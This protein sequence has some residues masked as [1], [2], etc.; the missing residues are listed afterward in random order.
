MASITGSIPLTN[1]IAPNSSA[2]SYPI[3]KPIYGLGGL[4]TV[5]NTGERDAITSARR[6][7]GMVVYVADIQKY[8][9]LKGPTGNGDWTE[10]LLGSS[11]GVTGATGARG[12]TGSTGAGYLATS[13]SEIELSGFSV[14]ESIQ[15]SVFAIPL[16]AYSIGQ[17]LIILSDSNNFFIGTVTNW[18]SVASTV[19]LTITKLVG[20]ATS[21]S[22]TINLVGEQG[23]QGNTGNTGNP[24]DLYKTTS[25][26]LI[27]LDG[28]TT[29]EALTVIIPSGFAYSK[30]QGVLLANTSSNKL[31]ATVSNYS[32]ITLSIIVD[33]IFGTGGYTF[34]DVNLAGAVGQAGPQGLQGPTGNV[35]PTGISGPYVTTFNGLTGAVTG[36]CANVGNTFIGTQRFQTSQVNIPPVVIDNGVINLG[37]YVIATGNIDDQA[38]QNIIFGTIP[39]LLSSIDLFNIFIGSQAGNLSGN[40]SQGSVHNTIIGFNALSNS[41]DPGYSVAIGNNA[42]TSLTTIQ[43]DNNIAIGYNAGS[44]RGA[45]GLPLTVSSSSIFLGK[46]A[47]AAGNGQS[48]QI[49]IGNDAIGLGSN[50]TV[51]GTTGTTFA[52]IYGL[53]D[54]PSGISASNIINSINGLTG[55]VGFSAGTGITLTTSEN[56]LIISATAVSGLT[57]GVQSIG[58]LTG[59]IS[60][61]AGTGISFGI[62]GNTLTIISTVSGSCIG[63]CAGVQSLSGLTGTV[64]LSAGTGIT[65]TTSGNTLIIAATAV[66]GITSA[67]L[68]VNGLT[69]TV[70]LSAGTGISITPSGNTLNITNTG[71]QTLTGLPGILLTGSTGA[72]TITNT[73]VTSL[74][75]SSG[76]TLS[77][78]SGAITISNSGVR[79]INNTETGNVTNVAK[80]NAANTFTSNQAITRKTPKLTLSDSET[81]YSSAFEANQISFTSEFITTQTWIPSVAASTISFPGSTGT[82]ALT[83]GTVSRINGL[84]GTVGLS[85]GT[86]ITLSK[87]GN[88]LTISATAV[89]G[90]TSAVLSIRGL[91]GIVGLSAGTGISITPSGNTL[92]IAT[93]NSGSCGDG[94]AIISRLYPRLPENGLCAGDLISYNGSNA[95][96]P[97]PREYLVTPSIWQ[98][99]KRVA[100]S[101]DVGYPTSTVVIPGTGTLQI[102]GATAPVGELIQMSL[103]GDDFGGTTLGIGTWWLNYVLYGSV[104]SGSDVGL[105]KGSYSGLTLLNAPRFYTATSLGGANRDVAGFAMLVRGTTYNA[106]DG[107]GGPYGNTSCSQD[108]NTMPLGVG[109]DCRGNGV[110]DWI[111]CTPRYSY[112]FTYGGEFYECTPI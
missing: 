74:N 75:A 86:G 108:P 22:W 100:I 111:T 99:R 36:V 33:T 60:L 11:G 66:S 95:W 72:I 63:A 40:G 52:R 16:P 65:L 47:R 14:G 97:I 44:K 55:T 102:L 34:W 67:V 106:F 6:E 38:R 45:A 64:G 13:S 27:N 98:T 19:T 12:T 87:S 104:G 71:V 7:A 54:L 84:T 85:A 20:S 37:N 77:G 23:L 26:T 109:S 50:S 68:N 101:P 51:I 83:S 30:A 43:P 39:P 89:S 103:S 78:S 70:G 2:D 17:S 110:M 18:N 49:V 88:T 29:G 79:F 9:T 3:T 48:N 21:S 42:L 5:G 25:S 57:S 53:L 1:F 73:G 24:G 107:R 41:T 69:G 10:F 61:V 81:F 76:I 56:T 94:S 32:G 46:D 59:V 92:T 112:G 105:F 62:S 90:I 58:G 15:V 35:G 8:Y 96:T 28:I 80:T 4:R 93:T 82:L 31:T 91:T